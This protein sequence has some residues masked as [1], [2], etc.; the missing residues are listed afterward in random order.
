MGEADI[1]PCF[2]SRGSFRLLRYLLFCLLILFVYLLFST[3][4]LILLALV[5]HCASPFPVI[6]HLLAGRAPYVVSSV[7]AYFHKYS[8]LANNN[9]TAI[10]HVERVVRPLAL[11]DEHSHWHI[12]SNAGLPQPCHSASC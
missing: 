7:F 3:L 1:S 12:R 4:V 6:P 8:C 9:Y 2:L 5:P 10:Y 11:T